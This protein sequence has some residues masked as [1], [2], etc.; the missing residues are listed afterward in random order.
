LDYYRLPED[1]EKIAKEKALQK[2]VFLDQI[3]LANQYNKPLIVHIRDASSDSLEILQS[4]TPKCGG[5]L[6]CYNADESLL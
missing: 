4:H 5:V 1:E 6:H 3:D 2:E